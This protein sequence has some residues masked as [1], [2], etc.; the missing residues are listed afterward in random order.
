MGRPRIR[1][2]ESIAAFIKRMDAW[3]RQGN[4]IPACG[5]TEKP[6][7]TRTRHRVLYVWQPRSGRHAYLDMGTDMIIP[8]RDLH[9]YGLGPTPGHCRRKR[10]PGKSR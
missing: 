1:T 7:R 8:D 2:K 4:W 3:K 9:L 6:F 10:S 5:G